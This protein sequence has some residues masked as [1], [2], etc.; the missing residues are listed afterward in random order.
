DRMTLAP[1]VGTLGVTN[2]IAKMQAEVERLA[3]TPY[4]KQAQG[5]LRAAQ[6]FPT[7]WQAHQNAGL[8]LSFAG[9]LKGAE[10]ELRAA[11]GLAPHAME[12]FF[13]LAG[14]LAFQ[15]RPFEAI[16]IYERCLR[17]DPGNFDV[18]A[19]LGVVE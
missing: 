17:F 10:R 14:V 11:M 6:R 5:A 4:A 2:R 13:S 18:L 19:R 12:P 16:E 1:F 8:L 7:D 3:R 15:K 9:D